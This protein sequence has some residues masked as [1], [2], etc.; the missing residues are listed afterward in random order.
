[1]FF[2][3]SRTVNSMSAAGVA[4]LLIGI[5]SVKA[6]FTEAHGLDKVVTLSN[7]CFAMP[8]AVFGALHLS[9]AAGLSQMVPKFM[10][11]PL[12]WAYFVGCALLSASLSIATKRYVFWSGLFFGIMMFLFVAMMDL[13]GVLSE[14]HNRIAWEL[15]LREL[16]FGAGGWMLAAATMT[17]P[18]EQ[19][20]RKAFAALGCVIIG[21][22]CVLYGVENF[23][24]PINVPAVPLEMMM[25]TWIPARPLIGYLT[26]AILFVTGLGILSM[27]KARM[28]ATYLGAWVVLL[29]VLIYGPILISALSNPS[30]DVKVQGLNYFFDTL[31]FAGTVL[32]LASTTKS[33]D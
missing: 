9:A 21:T 12:F 16:S 3:V 8:L 32:A 18:D 23:L 7:L 1:M 25:P 31:L 29:V 4:L 14:L 19:S 30:T 20:R 27:K 33:S 26:A 2:E 11:W 13:P 6:S 10:P 22:T 5:F 28:A 15:M 24:H 17:K